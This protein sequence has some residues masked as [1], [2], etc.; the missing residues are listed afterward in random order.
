MPALNF[1]FSLAPNVKC[2]WEGD[3]IPGYT[4]KGMILST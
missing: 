2:V 4:I 1:M 3:V